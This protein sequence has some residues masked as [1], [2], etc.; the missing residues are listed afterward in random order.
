M[1]S[2]LGFALSYWIFN[3]AATSKDGWITVYMTQF[4]VTMFPI[5]LTVPLYYWGKSLRRF[6]RNSSLHRMEEMI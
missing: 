3:V 1:H 6:Y 4:A 5:L 2:Q